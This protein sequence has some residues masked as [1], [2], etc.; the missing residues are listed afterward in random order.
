MLHYPRVLRLMG[1]LINIC[2]V[3][4]ES[5]HRD[6]KQTARNT[7]SRVNINHTI[8]VQN[9]LSFN[10]RLEND[11]NDSSIF[12]LFKTGILTRTRWEDQFE[13]DQNWN[14][15]YDHDNTQVIYTTK[16]VK[17]LRSEIRPG[18]V[19]IIPE[20]L[21][22]KFFKVKKIILRE[23]EILFW[24]EKLKCYYDFHYDA[25]EVDLNYSNKCTMIPLKDI[26]NNYYVSY[27]QS[28]P[29]NM[30]PRRAASA[31]TAACELR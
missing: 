23:N 3:C 21:K 2:S 4:C 10:S 15:G 18:T 29:L 9:Q 13:P 22:C 1:P 5:K 24:G 28:V 11:Q 20:N 17:I 25:F 19:I 7:R 26:Y 30:Q 16:S 31:Y 14:D 8:A 27:L 6:G 12:S